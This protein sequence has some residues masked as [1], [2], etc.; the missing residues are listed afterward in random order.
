MW[1]DQPFYLTRFAFE[2]ESS[3]GVYMKTSDSRRL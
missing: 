2:G 3:F 1:E